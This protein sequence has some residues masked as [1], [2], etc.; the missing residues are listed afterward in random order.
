MTYN[1]NGISNWNVPLSELLYPLQGANGLCVI[2][3]TPTDD[4][5]NLILADT[6]SRSAYVVY[7]LENYQVGLAQASY[8]GQ[9]NIEPIDGT[10]PNATPA[11][12]YHATQFAQTVSY[13]PASSGL[14]GSGAPCATTTTT[15]PNTHYSY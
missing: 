2:G 7:D 12:S 1:L 10:I 6:F 11:P 14:F 5:G 15:T 3:I 9:S 13:F 8:S 4:P